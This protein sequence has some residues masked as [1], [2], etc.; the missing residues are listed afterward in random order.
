MRSGIKESL[1]ELRVRK[2]LDWNKTQPRGSILE[3]GNGSV[4]GGQ[5]PAGWPG[6]WTISSGECLNDFLI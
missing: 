3:G 6:H 4:Q 5:N 1:V 2:N